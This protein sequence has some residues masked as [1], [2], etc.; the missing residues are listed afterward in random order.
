LQQAGQTALFSSVF[1][2][3]NGFYITTENLWKVSII[4][5][6]RQLI[7]HTWTNHNDQFLQPSEPLSD[8]FKN[9]CLIYML[10]HGKNCTASADGLEWN[11]KTWSIVNHFIPYTEAEVGANGRFESDFMVKY[12]SDKKCSPEAR[13]VLDAGR[14][15]WQAYFA[16]TDTHS[17]RDELKLNRPDVGWYQI[18]NALK[19]RNASGDAK[20]VDFSDFEDAYKALT[21][22]LVPMVYELGFLKD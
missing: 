16:Q 6:V 20:P 8:E 12:L 21:E 2:A 11:E 7:K 10:F 19:K 13:A 15:L 14:V 5:S 18:R 17:V 3:G 9:D 4:F 1:S 22:K